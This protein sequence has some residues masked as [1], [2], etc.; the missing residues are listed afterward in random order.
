MMG[1]CHLLLGKPDEA[2]QILLK[3]VRMEVAESGTE[4]IRLVQ[5]YY[6][7]G[8]GYLRMTKA[9]Q[10]KEYLAKSLRGYR[11]HQLEDEELLLAIYLQTGVYYSR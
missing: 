9:I 10:A 7:I 3:G 11:A 2:V 5:L 1:C 4:S 6:W 8:E